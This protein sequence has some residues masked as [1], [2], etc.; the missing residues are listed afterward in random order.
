MPPTDTELY[1]WLERLGLPVAVPLVARNLLT[2]LE[3]INR[4]MPGVPQETV[5]GFLRGIDLHK[6]VRLIWLQPGETVSAFRRFGE[7]LFKLFYTKVG[8]SPDRLGIVP[9]GRQFRRFV[10]RR[11]VEALSSKAAAFVY[12]SAEDPIA[13]TPPWRWPGGGGG[14]QYIIP[15]A[16]SSLELIAGSGRAPAGHA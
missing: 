16:E 15:D 13:G 5:E 8:T 3:F 9:T 11:T 1:V 10:V 7:P 12:A 14:I 2:A 6:E 4:R